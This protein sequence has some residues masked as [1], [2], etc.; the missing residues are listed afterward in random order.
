[1]A[2]RHFDFAF[3]SLIFDGPILERIHSRRDYGEERRI[4]IGMAD[5]IL[6]TLVYTGPPTVSK[7]SAALSQPAS[8]TAMS[9]KRTPTSSPSRRTAPSR[10]RANLAR[11]R[12]VGEAE[13]ARTAP[14]EL[15]ELPPDFW[16]KA[17]PVVP[18]T[19]TPISLRV[20]ADVLDWFRRNGPRYQSRM[21][22][23]LRS[24]MEYV[25]KAGKKRRQR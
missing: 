12:G 1:M 22:A 18:D 21:N 4:A 24:Y 17:L 9:A 16:D 13:I 3:A 25:A 7:S 5:G 6:M 20:D 19:K 23:V 10:G 11:L 15:R 14:G 8:A 2:K